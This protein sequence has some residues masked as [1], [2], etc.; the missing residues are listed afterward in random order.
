M[1]KITISLLSL[2]LLFSLHTNIYAGAKAKTQSNLKRNT[3][4]ITEAMS[5][6][7]GFVFT[8]IPNQIYKI[9]CKPGRLTDIQL[10]RNEEI[11]FIG[12]GDTTRWMVDQAVSGVG[13]ARQ[14]HIYVKP[15]RADISTNV[16]INTN[17]RSYHLELHAKKWYTPIISW[18]YEGQI[19]NG[20]TF[21]KN[22]KGNKG[23][24]FYSNTA[25]LNFK[26]RI[27]GKKYLLGKKYSFTPEQVFDDGVKTYFKMP[28][29]MTQKE[30]PVLFIK[31]EKRFMLVNYR[32]KDKYYIIDRLFQEAELRLGK[33][34]VKIKRK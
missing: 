8:Y 10:Q 19:R 12:G 30:A 3:Q 18:S 15:L 25:K 21:I 6:Q 24:V 14:I 32:V 13:P 33:K 26:Y 31:D 16:I 28:D 34:K 7:A 4:K 9:Y 5:N 1:K 23:A 17:R 2:G 11:L 27:R 22:N 29:T 20:G